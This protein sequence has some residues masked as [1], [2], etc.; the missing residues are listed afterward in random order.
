VNPDEAAAD[1]DLKSLHGNQRFEALI[2]KARQADAKA[3]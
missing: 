2:A 1:P 3:K